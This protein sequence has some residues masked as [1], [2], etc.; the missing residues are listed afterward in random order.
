[1]LLMPIGKNMIF[2]VKYATTS[3]FY[4]LKDGTIKAAIEAN[5]K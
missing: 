3:E 1:M 5:S 4:L 2:F